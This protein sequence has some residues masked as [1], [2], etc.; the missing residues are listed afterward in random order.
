MNRRSPQAAAIFDLDRTLIAGASGPAF[1]H[2]LDAAGVKQRRLPGVD[3][4]ASTY[5]VLGE[6]ALTAPAARLAAR[7]TAGW[8][9]DA[10]EAAATAAVDELMEQVQPYAPGVIDDHHEAGRVLVMATTSPAPL[11]TPFAEKLGFDAVVATRWAVRDGA[12]TGELDG[13]IVWGRGKLEAVRAWATEAGVDLGQS[14]AYSDSYYDAPLLDAVRYPTAVNADLRLVALARIK[15]WPLRHFDLPEGV[16]KIAGRELQAWTRPLQDT[17]MLPNVEIDVAGVEK[18]P[19]SGPVIAV[20]NHRSYFDATVV[21]SVLGQTGR[22][23]R[24]LGKKE[25]F[26]APVIGFFSK[27]AG[28]IR[29]NRASGSSEPLEHAIRALKA[30]DAVALAPEGTIPRGPAFF[31]PE[32]KGRWGAARLAQATGAPVIPVGLWGTEKVW[33]RNRRLPRFDLNE[34]PVIRVRVGDPVALKHRSLEADTKRI[35][36]ALVD[37]LPPEAK[38]RHTPTAEELAAT[39]PAGYKGDPHAEVARRP[40]TDT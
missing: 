27:M 4:V 14:Y 18:I 30:G 34:R 16:L 22:P 21:G 39:Y 31:D 2:H 17:R 26:D 6:T 9:V 12:Y 11:V 15:G 29:V 23:F 37:Q 33:P 3:V 7:A 13:G 40:G 5:R 32:L 38:V 24:F 36:A 8:P 1:A 35:M 28:G 19:P 10:V 20:F 25:V